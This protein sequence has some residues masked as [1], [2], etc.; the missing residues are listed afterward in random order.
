MQDCKW[1]QLRP[2]VTVRTFIS[3]CHYS[4]TAF[5]KRYSATEVL[6]VNTDNIDPDSVDRYVSQFS[7]IQKYLCHVNIRAYA[8]FLFK[9]VPSFQVLPKPNTTQIASS[10]GRS[11]SF[12]LLCD[13][14][15]SSCFMNTLSFPLH[16]EM[17]F[18]MQLSKTSKYIP[19]SLK[20][21]PVLGSGTHLG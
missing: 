10:A 2:N 11:F 8:V 16:F 3:L 18:F 17:F 19:W 21:L 14:H 12:Q 20:P 13:R 6:N 7:P 4:L 15:T 5:T 9:S 1:Q